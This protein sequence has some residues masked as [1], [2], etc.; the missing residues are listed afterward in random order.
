MIR[1]N[2]KINTKPIDDLIER[3]ADFGDLVGGLAEE[4][5]AE[6][7]AE[8]LYELQDYPP[9]RP[10]QKYQRTYRL[11]NGWEVGGNRTPNGF[12]VEIDNSTPYAKYVVGSFAKS[13]TAAA[14]FQAEVHQGR[15]VLAVDTLNFWYEDFTEDFNQKFAASFAQF[16]TA[17]IS[18]KAFTR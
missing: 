9:P 11:K 5:F 12:E 15:W 4:V 17:S 14:E 6:R 18:K 3:A 8:L 16:G 1:S 13:R 7:E 2:W 10:N